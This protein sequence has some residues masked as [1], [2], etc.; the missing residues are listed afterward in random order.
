MS[1]L[2]NNFSIFRITKSHVTHCTSFKADNTEFGV[3]QSKK[4]R[5]DYFDFLHDSK[6]TE[7]KG[8]QFHQLREGTTLSKLI[9][10]TV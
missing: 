4:S 7:P 5:L 3:R 2:D 6:T 10:K 9:S 1:V 8:R